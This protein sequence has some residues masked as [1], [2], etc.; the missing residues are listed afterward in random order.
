[1]RCSFSLKSPPPRNAISQWR[2]WSQRSQSKGT[3]TGRTL[4]LRLCIWKLRI[5]VFNKIFLVLVIQKSRWIHKIIISRME[6]SLPGYV[7]S[8]LDS[9]TDLCMEFSF[10]FF[11]NAYIFAYKRYPFWAIQ[12]SVPI[13]PPSPT[14][15]THPFPFWFLCS[16]EANRMPRAVGILLL[17]VHC[18]S[19]WKQTVKWFVFSP[20]AFHPSHEIRTGGNDSRPWFL[21]SLKL[22]LLRF[23]L[24]R[25]PY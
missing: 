12:G 18:T 9:S 25:F 3:G 20:S 15:G 4:E 1:M 11:S 7:Q 16:V 14:V 24:P 6:N 17:I 22:T 10:L 2:L 8:L 19:S 23:D 21:R 5:L 13:I